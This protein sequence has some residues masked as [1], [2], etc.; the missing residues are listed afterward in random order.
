MNLCVC[1]G[2][3]KPI[4]VSSKFL[5]RIFCYWERIEFEKDY[6]NVLKATEKFGVEYPVVLDNDF[7][8]WRAYRN[9]YWPRKF[10]IDIDGFIVYDHIGEGAYKE[11]ETKIQ[12][13][14]EERNSV[15]GMKEV[16]DNSI[17]N[18]KNAETVSR[19]IGTPE[20]YFGYGFS[21]NQLGNKEGWVKDSFVDYM[22]P[23]EFIRNFFYLEGRWYNHYDGM[24]LNDNFGKVILKYSAKDVNI[25]AGSNETVNLKVYVDDEFHKDVQVKNHDLYNVVSM[26]DYGEHTLRI[27]AKNGF[28]IFTFTFG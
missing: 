7:K 15:L 12:E 10:L 26:D 23:S 17:V 14:L 16:I 9:R 19:K 27:E 20:I 24:I 5:C 22:L 1:G 6:E 8:T 18:P 28:E 21:R 11:T 13:L 2:T 3:G 25:V 4:G